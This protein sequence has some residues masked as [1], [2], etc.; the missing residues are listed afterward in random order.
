[1]I[2]LALVDVPREFRK[3]YVELFVKNE[4]V[5]SDSKMDLGMAPNTTHT[6]NLKDDEPQYTKQFTIPV[7]HMDMIKTNVREWL[8]LGIIESAKSPYNA[9]IFCVP[10]K[11]GLGLRLVCDFRAVNQKTWPDRYSMRSVDDCLMEIGK[12]NSKIFSTIDLT[13][14]FWQMKLAQE[15]RPY[16]AFTIPGWGQFQWK[17]G[18]MGL[19]GC[20]ASFARMMDTIMAGQENII[21]YIDDLLIHSS[22]WQEHLQHLD[23][24]FK[25]LVKNN[26]KVNLQK[27]EFGKAEVAYLGHTITGKGVRP[28]EDKTKAI[29]AAVAPTTTKQVKSFA[30]LCNYF[31]SYIKDFSQVAAPLFALTRQ[32]SEWKKGPLP[33]EARHAFLKLK[34]QLTS[35]P[36]M[37]FPT[38][39]GE[40]HLYVDAAGGVDGGEGGLGAALF[41]IQKTQKRLIAYASRRLQTHEKNYSAFLLEKAAAVYGIDHFAHLLRGRKFSLFTDHRPLTKLSTTHTKTLN[42]LQQKLLEFDFEIKYVPGGDNTVADFLS[43]SVGAEADHN[44]GVGAAALDDGPQRIRIAQTQDE[45]CRTILRDLAKK[46]T[47]KIGERWISEFRIRQDVIRVVLKPRK[48]FP[49]GKPDRIFA[50]KSMRPT[51]IKQGHDAIIAGHGGTFKTKE[52]IAEQFWWPS[53]EADVAEHVKKCGPCNMAD[54]RN[55]TTDTG[56]TPL[57]QPRNPNE[58]V[59]IDLFGPL[60]GSDKKSKFVFVATDAFTKIVRLA[61]IPDKSAPVVAQAIT[62][63]WINIF[64]VM[65]VAVT[66]QG[67]EFNNK[68]QA[69][70]WKILDVDHKTTTPYHPRCNAQVEI[71]NKTMGRY[72]RTM[73]AQK[74]DTSADW[75][76]LIGPLMFAHNTAVNKATRTTPFYAMFGYDPRAPLWPDMDVLD[77]DDFNMAKEDEKTL[78]LEFHRRQAAVRKIAHNNNQAAR[79]EY[80]RPTPHPERPAFEKG[81]KVWIA[82]TP[83]RG[84]NRKLQPRWE[85][86]II[87]EEVHPGAFRVRRFIGKRRMKTISAEQI[88][89]R[90]D[91]KIPEEEEEEEKEKEE[92]EEEE[93]EDIDAMGLE[94]YLETMAK[95][96][97]DVEAWAGSK[98][99]WT[100]RDLRKLFLEDKDYNRAARYFSLALPSFTLPAANEQQQQQQQPP[101]PVGG[102]G[103]GAAKRLRLQKML[104]NRTRTPVKRRDPS[105]TSADEEEETWGTPEAGPSTPRQTHRVRPTRSAPASSK[106]KTRQWFWQEKK[107]DASDD[108]DAESTTSAASSQTKKTAEEE[109]PAAAAKVRKWAKTRKT[110]AKR[111]EEEDPSPLQQL[112]KHF[113]ERKKRRERSP[114]QRGSPSLHKFD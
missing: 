107:E 90:V 29:R 28:G 40:F 49:P 102:G 73:L 82:T 30:G 87:S 99:D 113:K 83:P 63:N 56:L 91:D 2:N 22:G 25:L 4:A 53:M 78:L 9:P 1:M 55:P 68:L 12:K 38:S 109:Y 112:T 10:K 20:P 79:E 37:A 114:D 26:L 74:G 64:G 18:A 13:S 5:F 42:R 24:A 110:R 67:L 85:K 32:D 97:D 66:D 94:E 35:R 89:A 71:F 92:E 46:K 8:K 58:R 77:P 52:R 21:T 98:R 81:D 54:T 57:P 41:Q 111:A 11:S 44:D 75:E 36:V 27:C 88:R 47:P 104:L 39:D 15:S 3:R 103:G 50:P 76:L 70:I 23:T 84:K 65:A 14:G 101:H 43:R 93:E 7:A 16:T 61:V 95:F 69:A 60:V 19:A 31:R 33:A 96:T 6:I 86:A 45:E 34:G 100:L 105:P 59:H 106:T 51:L 108:S 80:L 17:R 62:D 48:G 72:L